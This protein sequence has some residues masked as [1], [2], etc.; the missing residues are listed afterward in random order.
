VPPE[1]ILIE[2]SGISYPAEVARTFLLPELK[3]YLNVDSILAL[4]DSEQ[5]LDLTGEAAVLAVEQVSMSDIVILNKVD[6]AEEN[7][8][9]AVR[10]WVRQ[11]IPMARILETEHAHVAMDFILSTGGLDGNRLQKLSIGEVH[12]HSVD[13][14]PFFTWSYASD[15]P[16]AFKAVREVI[17]TLPPNI[18][19]AKGFVYFSEVPS[20]RGIFQLA[21]KRV[22]LYLAEPWGERRPHTQLMFISTQEDIDTMDLQL[23]F[24]SCRAELLPP[25]DLD[26]TLEEIEDWIRLQ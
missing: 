4:I 9:E 19:R 24:D 1:Y 26:L 5:V 3:A 11:I 21:G 2:A 8:L 17:Q 7:Q 6:L 25:E 20:Q 22:S 10:A 13:S 18:I 23:R 14:H 12:S 15:Q 16:L